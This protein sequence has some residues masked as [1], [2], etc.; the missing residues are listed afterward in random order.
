MPAPRHKEENML[1]DK[2]MN[3]IRAV[4]RRNEYCLT[5]TMMQGLF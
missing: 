3:H 2:E 1:T 4:N 5:P